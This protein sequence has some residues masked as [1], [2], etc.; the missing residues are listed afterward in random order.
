MLWWSSCARL[1][2]SQ[3]KTC[4]CRWRQ[5]SKYTANLNYKYE[6]VALFT[7]QFPS[8]I[9]AL[10]PT[11]SKPW[12]HHS[13][14]SIVHTEL[15]TKSCPFFLRINLMSVT[16]FCFS[17]TI[18]LTW[19]QPPPVCLPWFLPL[20]SPLPT[21]AQL[22]SHKHCSALTCSQAWFRS[23][24]CRSFSLNVFSLQLCLLFFLKRILSYH[25]ISVLQFTSYFPFPRLRNFL[26]FIETHG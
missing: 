4:T 13:F 24:L 11:G 12:S 8:E 3:R 21:D 18:N 15:V 16:L 17:T 2:E 23:S 14:L 5:K 19:G 1:S 7:F 9:P 26:S 25:V 20:E 22:T 6:R 10:G